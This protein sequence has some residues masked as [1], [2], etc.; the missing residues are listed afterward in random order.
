MCFSLFFKLTFSWIFW[1]LKAYPKPGILLP[2]PQNPLFLPF[3]QNQIP[4][5]LTGRFG[6]YPQ[7]PHISSNH[8]C[9]L[10]KCKL[11]FSNKEILV[12]T[13]FF[14]VCTQAQTH[15]TTSSHR[16]QRALAQCCFLWAL[17]PKPTSS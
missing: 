8:L 17:S 10:L 1:I 4:L 14:C 6:R 11:F 9:R 3:I 5:H 15:F 12:K 7:S 13:S 16:R 2:F